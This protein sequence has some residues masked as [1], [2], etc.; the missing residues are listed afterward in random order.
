MW[1]VMKY[2]PNFWSHS[3]FSRTWSSCALLTFSSA[4]YPLVVVT[5]N[6]VKG[7]VPYTILR[8]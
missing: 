7:G 6:F 3:F 2:P 4:P 1:I 5:L 8:S